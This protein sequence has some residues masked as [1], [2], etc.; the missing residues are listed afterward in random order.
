MPEVSNFMGYQEESKNN[1]QPQNPNE[2]GKTIK[3]LKQIDSLLADILGNQKSQV[4]G[5]N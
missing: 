1:Q 3:D 5:V 2:E 4:E